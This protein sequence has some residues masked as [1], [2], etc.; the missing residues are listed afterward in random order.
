V[1]THGEIDAAVA[2]LQA[3]A[4]DPATICAGPRHFEVLT[5]KPTP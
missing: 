5:R 2:A 4:D 1:A 3:A